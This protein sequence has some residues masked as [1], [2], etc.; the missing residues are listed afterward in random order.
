MTPDEQEALSLR[1][2]NDVILLLR[3]KS[4]KIAV[5]DNS[6]QLIEIIDDSVTLKE[7]VVNYHNKPPVLYREVKGPPSLQ[8]P[9]PKRLLL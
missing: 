3:L 5:F 6:R 7:V 1:Y 4:C 8:A 2:G 9:K